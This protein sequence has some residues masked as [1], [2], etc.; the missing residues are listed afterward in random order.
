M[1]LLLASGNPHKAEEF[2][3]L[4]DPGLF[5]IKSAPIKV[6]VTEDGQSFQENAYKKAKAYYDQFKLPVLSDD[7]GIVV[8]ALPEELGIYSAR[9][10]GEHLTDRERAELLLEKLKDTE[11]RQAYFVCILCFYLSPGEIFFFEGRME[12]EIGTVYRGEYGFG[13][14][15]VFIPSKHEGEQTVA[16]IPE[17]KSK[18]GHRSQACKHADRFFRER[19]CQRG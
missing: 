16:E 17:W 9:F 19:N 4:L 12:G 2:A 8:E 18:N 15:P 5:K 14:D 10:G 1:N 11:K 7:S 13:Y 3:D 6:S